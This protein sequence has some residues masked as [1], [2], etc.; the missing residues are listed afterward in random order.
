MKSPTAGKCL[1]CWAC[2]AALYGDILCR[3][4]Q[5]R[6]AVLK[7]KRIFGA[8]IVAAAVAVA[9]IQFIPA[10]A[11]L[12]PATLPVEQ[13]NE[14]RL[15]NF[16]GIPNFRDL[17]G[18][19]ASDGRTVK[20]GRLYRSG[21]FAEASR[22]DL[23]GLQS[24]ELA[25][26][27]DFRSGVEKTEEPNRLPD[28]AGFAVVDIPVL[29]EGN[30]N[31][32]GE[33]SERI[34]TDNFDGFEPGQVME[35][36]NRQFADEFTPQFRQFIHA[37]LDANGAPV[38][39]HCTAG[40]DRT[41]FAAAILLRILGIPQDTVM[42]DYMASRQPA[43]E[44]RHSELLMLRIFKGEDVAGKISVLLGVEEDWLEAGF[45][46]IDATWGSFDNYVSNGLQ[47]SA[48]DIQRL[49]DTL[50]E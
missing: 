9:V 36:A 47:L 30:K 10:P 40:K 41:G 19:Q 8:G 26:F 44:A 2:L 32:F 12:V 45:D 29:D 7:K 15:L 35:Q 25:T 24:L 20:W 16:E 49:R 42:A 39:W 21:N 5:Q 37:V 11:L 46:E 17:G 23:A 18:Y 3:E 27:I 38:L 4:N 34:E 22:A 6:G 1:F 13:R 28:P 14:H 43:L 50:L 48:A 31:L 33:I